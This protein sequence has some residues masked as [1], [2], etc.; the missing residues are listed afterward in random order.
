[1]IFKVRAGG[2]IFEVKNGALV[3]IKNHTITPVIMLVRR[4]GC[5]VLSDLVQTST[6][7]EVNHSGAP[8]PTPNY[9]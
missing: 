9:I 6:S 1:M 5:V 8:R 7:E 4:R 3:L 2:L